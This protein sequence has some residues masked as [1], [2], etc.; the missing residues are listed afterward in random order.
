PAPHRLTQHDALPIF[1]RSP[2]KT[3]LTSDISLLAQP[4]ERLE[5][6]QL[7]V[8][9]LFRVG[10]PTEYRTL[11]KDVELAPGGHEL[12]IDQHAGSQLRSEEHTSELQ[13]RGHL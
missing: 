4:G 12:R 11:F 3:Q 6:D 13:S 9:D 10:Y 2:G 8:L 7:G 5:L 1:R